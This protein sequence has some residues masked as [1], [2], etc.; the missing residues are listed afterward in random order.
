MLAERPGPALAQLIGEARTAARVKA[1][2]ASAA[3][4][5]K[6]RGLQNDMADHLA[7]LDETGVA[8][9]AVAARA[10]AELP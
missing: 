8:D 10:R 2:G 3:A 9:N 4:R 5:A 7:A 6:R 1:A